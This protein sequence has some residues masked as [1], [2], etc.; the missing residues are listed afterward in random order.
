LVRWVPVSEVEGLPGPVADL[1]HIDERGRARM[2]DVTSKSDTF[3]R[4]LVRAQ[5]LNVPNTAAAIT[6]GDSSM[7]HALEAARIAALG[8][9]K[10]TSEL[11]PLCHPLPLSRIEVE[12]SVEGEGLS[13]IAVTETTGK[14]GV[15]MEALSACALAAVTLLRPAR[16]LD[17]GAEMS[18]LT[19][20]EKRGG[21]TGW[22]H[23]DEDGEMRHDPEPDS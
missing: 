2:V 8:G 7:R 21:R 22:W 16:L 13:I 6:S 19:L 9:A 17:P 10:R 14:T 18:G 15:E 20:F 23:R 4:A 1:T 12:I 5:I 11:I 3:R